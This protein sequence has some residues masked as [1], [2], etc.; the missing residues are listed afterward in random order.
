[1]DQTLNLKFPSRLSNV[2]RI[3]SNDFPIGLNFMVVNKHQWTS[4]DVCFWGPLED[5][6]DGVWMEVMH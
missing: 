5:D 1:M 3:W 6:L 2:K 4:S